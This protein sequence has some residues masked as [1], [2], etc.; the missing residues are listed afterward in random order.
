MWRTVRTIPLVVKTVQFAVNYHSTNKQVRSDIKDKLNNISEIVRYLLNI[1]GQLVPHHYLA[2]T[3]LWNEDLRFEAI[4]LSAGQTIMYAG[5][6]TDG[7]DGI[8][9][10]KLCPQW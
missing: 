5:G 8:K 1:L 10:L 7:A 9:L 4:S 6:N 3:G 2:Q